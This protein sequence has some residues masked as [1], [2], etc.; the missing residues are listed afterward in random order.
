VLLFPSLCLDPTISLSRSRPKVD[1]T[2]LI[3]EL[4]R[5][6]NVTR[7][8]QESEYRRRV[9]WEQDLEAK[10]E[11]RQAE[12]ETQLAEMKQEITHLKK[13]VDSLLHEQPHDTSQAS[14]SEYPHGESGSS[15]VVPRAAISERS[16]RQS[17]A[18]ERMSIDA[19]SRSA[20][21]VSPNDKGA[22]PSPNDGESDSGDSESE[23][24]QSLTGMRFQKRTNNHDKRCYTIQVL[25]VTYC[26]MTLK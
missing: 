19:P 21:P 15:P 14:G 3:Q 17:T 6:L 2:H 18:V 12:T 13:C 5:A 24:S 4:L 7:E 25:K 11:Q 1:A 20:S 8:A 16:S 10:Y 23:A 22:T 9:A 26:L